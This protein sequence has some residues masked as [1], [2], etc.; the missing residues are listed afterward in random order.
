MLTA[1]RYLC[2]HIVS[3]TNVSRVSIAI[4]MYVKD[5]FF[6]F[7]LAF[8]FCLFMLFLSRVRAYTYRRCCNKML[9]SCSVFYPMKSSIALSRTYALQI[10]VAIAN[11]SVK[12]TSHQRQTKTTMQ[13]CVR[14]SRS[15]TYTIVQWSG[16]GGGVWRWDWNVPV[17]AHSRASKQHDNMSNEKQIFLF[18]CT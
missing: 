17:F 2:V 5:I 4:G 18:L 1:S 12:W 14:T 16:Y 11:V 9:V 7:V 6:F 13:Y 8:H 3:R 15:R 10:A